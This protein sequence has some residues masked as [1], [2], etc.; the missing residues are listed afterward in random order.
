MIFFCQYGAGNQKI[1]PKTKILKNMTTEQIAESYI[2]GN[3][4]E[5]RR[6]ILRGTKKDVA[7]KVMD[8]H[9]FLRGNYGIEKAHLGFRGLVHNL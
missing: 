4:R 3:Y 8:V 6:E 9:E 7:K 2:N 5:V 1:H